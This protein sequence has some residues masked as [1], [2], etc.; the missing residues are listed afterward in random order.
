MA[1]QLIA[2]LTDPGSALTSNGVGVFVDE[3]LK[4]NKS[5]AVL[6]SS[7]A[8]SAAVLPKTTVWPSPLSTATPELSEA[9]NGPSRLALTSVVFGSGAWTAYVNDAMPVQ[10]KVFLRDYENFMTHMPTAFMNARIAGLPL[11]IAAALQAL[12][13]FFRS[14]PLSGRS[15]A[16]ATAIYRTRSL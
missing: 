14:L 8:R 3:R 9:P 16:A 15:D 6:K 4:L 7:S 13:S 2:G 10:T 11:P 12:V 1:G 5:L